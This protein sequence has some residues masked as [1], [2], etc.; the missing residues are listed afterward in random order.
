MLIH[1]IFPKLSRHRRDPKLGE[2]VVISIA[3]HLL[4]HDFLG[5]AEFGVLWKHGIHLDILEKIVVFWGL[6]LQVGGIAAVEG[7][8]EVLAGGVH[9]DYE[10]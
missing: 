1:T 6:F 4:T 8:D 10:L 7:P 2:H 3:A 9:V 5:V